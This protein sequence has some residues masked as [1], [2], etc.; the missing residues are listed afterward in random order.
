[1]SGCGKVQVQARFALYPFP[2]LGGASFIPWFVF[3]PSTDI[4]EVLYNLLQKTE[5]YSYDIELTDE[6][7]E[8][9]GVQSARCR[10][11]NQRCKTVGDGKSGNGDGKKSG[12]CDGELASWKERLEQACR[13]R[14]PNKKVNTLLGSKWQQINQAIK[15]F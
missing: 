7:V 3:L 11:G 4:F 8:L 14:Q 9:R 2:F 15:S 10:R 1:M 5:E 12:D 13:L 6:C